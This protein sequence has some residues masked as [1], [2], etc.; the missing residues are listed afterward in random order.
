MDMSKKKVFIEQP[1]GFEDP[2]RPEY[3]YQLKKALYVFKQAPIAWYE[4]LST[5]LIDHNFEKGMM[6]TT[7]FIKKKG[8]K[9]FVIQIYVDD[10]IIRATDDVLCK[11][12]QIS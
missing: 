3:V 9:L 8:K 5:F 12:L 11:T 7:L 1:L 10:I 4:R 6:D 2:G